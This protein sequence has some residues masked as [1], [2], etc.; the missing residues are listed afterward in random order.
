MENPLNNYEFP[1][2]PHCGWVKSKNFVDID[3]KTA[4][5]SHFPLALCEK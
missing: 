4:K 3:E 5:N 2:Q 1:G